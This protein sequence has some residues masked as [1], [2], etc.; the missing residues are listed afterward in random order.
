MEVHSPNEV[1]HKQK[2]WFGNLSD[3]GSDLL[4]KLMKSAGIKDSKAP[5]PE[6]TIEVADKFAVQTAEQEEQWTHENQYGNNEQNFHEPDDL[7]NFPLFK[8][9]D[10][11]ELEEPPAETLMHEDPYLSEVV[12][13]KQERSMYSVS[14]TSDGN[15]SVFTGIPIFSFS[16]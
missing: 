3:K 8:H 2:P 11:F 9:V 12:S 6:P 4:E 15:L 5:D 1:E 10:S 13:I 14:L 7:P 16:E